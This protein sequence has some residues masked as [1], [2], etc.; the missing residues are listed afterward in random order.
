MNGLQIT[1]RPEGAGIVRVSIA[2]E[3]DMATAPQVTD[4]ARDAVT[5]GAR[6]V[7]LDLAEVTFL[8]STGIRTL[9][10]AQRDAAEQGVLLRVVDAHHRVLRV[11]EITGA[12]ETLRDGA[13]LQ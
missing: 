4:A 8:D 12:L 1:T 3:I 2:G 9:L 5:S 7:R 6:E 10:F 13:T 11:L